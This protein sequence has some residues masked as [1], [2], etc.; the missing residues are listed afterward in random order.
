MVP[1]N[2]G[3][4]LRVTFASFN[5]EENWDFLYI[6]NGPDETFGDLS[7]GGL[8]GSAL[9]NPFNSTASNGSLTFKF[10]ADQGVVA[11][12]WN[13]T[14]T[15]TGTL[16][17]VE[18]DFIDYSYYPNPTN[19][20]VTINS[21]DPISEVLVYNVQG[22]LLFNQKMNEMTTNVDMSS[23]ANGTYFFKLKINNV[24]ANFKILKM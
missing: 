15:C 9:P 23:F 6:Y 20:T 21:K 8:T 10:Y 17:E 18:A 14:I 16:G 12:G 7:L 19:G 22:Q 13:A 4:K 24:E 3:L 5:L 11:S 2:P 1:S